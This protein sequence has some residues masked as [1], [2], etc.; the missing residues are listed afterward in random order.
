V[1]AP[2]TDQALADE[3]DLYEFTAEPARQRVA[4][5]FGI[6]EARLRQIE[7]EGRDKLWPLV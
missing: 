1:L 6:T 7:R 5:R 4:R 2:A 3:E